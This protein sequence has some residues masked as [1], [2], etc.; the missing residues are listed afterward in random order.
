MIGWGGIGWG[1][2]GWSGWDGWDGITVGL[3]L[4]IKYLL[5]DDWIKD[6]LEHWNK[7]H[8]CR[9]LL[10]FGAFTT[11]VYLLMKGPN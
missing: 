11:M 4:N 9:T 6:N 3:L 2:M 7:V 8:S 10:G 5:G 1:G